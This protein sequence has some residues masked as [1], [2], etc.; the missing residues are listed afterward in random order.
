MAVAGPPLLFDVGK[1]DRMRLAHPANEKSFTFLSPLLV[2][3]FIVSNGNK[4]YEIEL[5]IS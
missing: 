3:K 2:K 1:Y 5:R 4:F